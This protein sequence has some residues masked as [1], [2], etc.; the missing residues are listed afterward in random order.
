MFYKVRVKDPYNP[1]G[2]ADRD[3]AHTDVFVLVEADN[4]RTARNLA[5]ESIIEA[6]RATELELVRAGREGWPIIRESS[7]TAT[8]DGQQELPIPHAQAADTVEPQLEETNGIPR[9][10]IVQFTPSTGSAPHW[11]PANPVAQNTGG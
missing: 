3:L 2:C 9:G 4:I 11:L 8:D 5:V 1:T 6:E 10:E 7:E